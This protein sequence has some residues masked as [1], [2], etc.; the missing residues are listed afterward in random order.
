MTR[1]RLAL[2]AA[3]ASL[4][5]G[6]IAVPA[7]LAA[8]GTTASSSSSMPALDTVKVTGVGKGD[9]QFKGTYAI[10]G[11]TVSHHKAYAVG[12]LTG[13][14]KG[15]HVSRSGVMLPASLKAPTTGAARAAQA[16]SCPILHLVLGPINL[17][18][19]GLQVTTNQIILNITAIPG[20][21]NLL[22]NLLCDLTNALNPP[23]ILTTL[24][25]DLQ[26]LTSTLTS[27]VSLLGGTTGG[28]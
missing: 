23:G 10:Q 1:P 24:N 8:N 4:S 5:F 21:G 11:F 17:N 16:A 6:A 22:G 7:A 9:K 18:L 3:I 12:T 15:R 19:L 14:L 27:L 26:Q 28:L 20:A 13:T 2:V 25:S